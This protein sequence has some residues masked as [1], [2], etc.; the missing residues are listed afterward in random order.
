[1]GVC[2][3]P[4]VSHREQV[5]QVVLLAWYLETDTEG[6]MRAHA[7]REKILRYFVLGG[8][9]MCLPLWAVYSVE[10]GERW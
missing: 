5:A 6:D 7:G 10:C 2:T 9:C 4:V 1:M 3:V 8:V